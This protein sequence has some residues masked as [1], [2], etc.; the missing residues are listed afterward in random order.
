MAALLSCGTHLPDEA[1]GTPC[2]T[3]IADAAEA[4]TQTQFIILGHGCG[5]PKV[6][7][8]AGAKENCRVQPAHGTA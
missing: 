5:Q 3:A 1:A 6:H 2:A 7:S 4:Q 8:A